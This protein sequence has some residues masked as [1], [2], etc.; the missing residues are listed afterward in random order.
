[1][2]S[3]QEPEISAEFE[4]VLFKRFW[5]W[6]KITGSIVF[7]LTT[8]AWLLISQAII[9]NARETA[10]G[11]AQQGIA[12]FEGKMDSLSERLNKLTEAAETTSN[13]IFQKRGETQ[14]AARTSAETA[15]DIRLQFTNLERQI[16]EKSNLIKELNKLDNVITEI[17]SKP[18]F[19]QAVSKS[20]SSGFN[21]S[22]VAFAQECKTPWIPYKD[23]YARVI[24]GAIPSGDVPP[25]LINHI[26]EKEKFHLK[27]KHGEERVKL[28]IPELP[29]HTHL[30]PMDRTKNKTD[31]QSL[32]NSGKSDEGITSG[33]QE[34]G[35]AGNN[36][37][38]NNMPPYIAL[39]FCTL[40]IR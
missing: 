24:I 28:S 11:A 32:T 31:L 23:A 35:N 13:A 8:I 12:E 30:L 21:N 2:S 36:V 19:V 17:A 7:A 39:H 15:Q 37:A 14:E 38:H 34:T 25:E 3:T 33:G 9:P 27:E 26:K 20:V 40:E 6:L 16:A 5:L 18:A 1:M 22:V 10:R 4:R 29:A